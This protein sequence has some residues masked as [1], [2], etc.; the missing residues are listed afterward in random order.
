MGE[1]VLSA[2]LK[3]G[4][5]ILRARGTIQFLHIGLYDDRDLSNILAPRGGGGVGVRA[6]TPPPPVP[7]KALLFFGTVRLLPLSIQH[8]NQTTVYFL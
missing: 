6:C 8:P 7:Q 4:I 2:P 5:K 1:P 3:G